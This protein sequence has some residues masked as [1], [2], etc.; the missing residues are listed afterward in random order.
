MPKKP[1]KV[2][3][4]L[5]GVILYNPARIV[6]P[7]ITFVKRAVLHKSSTKFFIPRAYWEQ[8]VWKFLHKSSIFVA[9]GFEEIKQ[10]TQNKKIELYIITGRYSFLREDF[11]KWIKAIHAHTFVKDWY[12][13]EHDEQPHIF[14][15]KLITK[16][17]LDVF[18]ED[19]WDIVN[20]LN[21][22][23]SLLNSQLKIYWIYNIFDRKISYQQKFP[24]LKSAVAAIKKSLGIEKTK[25]L[26]VTD[27]FFP[28]WTG[29]AKT[30][31]NMVK[32]LSKRVYFTVLTVKFQDELKQKEKIEGATVLREKYLFSLS[33]SKYSLHLIKRFAQ[34][35]NKH[36]VVFIN[37]PCS[38][39][40]PLSFLTK[41]FWKKLIIF[42]QG[43]LILS[44]GLVNRII[45]KI[46]DISTITSCKLADTVS[47]YTRDYAEHSRVLKPFLHK[48]TPIMMPVYVNYPRG[49]GVLQYAPTKKLQSAAKLKSQGKILFGFAG[50]FVEEKGF[51]ILFDAIEQV[52]DK[53]SNGIFV[54]AGDTNISYEHFYDKHKD[55]LKKINDRVINV[56]LLNS[57]QLDYFYYLI[58]FIVISSRS[59]CFSL[60]QAEAILAGKPSIV[61]D[62]PG[63][64]YLVKESHF[65]LISEK[66]DPRDLASKL[67][68][69]VK[70]RNQ[71]MKQYHKALVLLDNEK[72]TE[73]ILQFLQS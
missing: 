53:I 26:L 46:F 10:L 29:I 68:Q 55:K 34:E 61:S 3:L 48:F 27:Y 18:V 39:I 60:V 40:L 15:E 16:L 22:Q 13:N 58:D 4:D 51:D 31:L 52:K 63:A 36:N 38:N 57:I 24:H 7:L 42:H 21:S 20:Y 49:R 1:L 67:I 19:N 14:K 11:E 73:K 66:E 59:D 65:G 45:E 54:F 6:R 50:R 35:V 64:R 43:D 62:I 37:S 72:N 44:E 69:A 71:L 47:T 23:L 17:N 32:A 8:I 28:H 41:M 30:M 12:F 5:D 9:P 2:G 56:G 25:V 33:R 70:K